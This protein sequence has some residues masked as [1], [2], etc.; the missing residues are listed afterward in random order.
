[1]AKKS[2][3]GGKKRSLPSKAPKVR[4]KRLDASEEPKQ[5]AH[6]PTVWDGE[7]E[8]RILAHISE[9]MSDRQACEAVGIA[10][11]TLWRKTA[12]DAGFCTASTR[13]RESRARVLADQ[14]I[15]IADE[16]ARMGMNGV[17]S[18]A[19]THRKTRI[20]TRFRLLAKLLPREYG[21]K[22]GVEH[23]AQGGLNIK[24]NLGDD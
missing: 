4:A 1:M 18:G 3:T 22:V 17:D 2:S 20:E 21:D 10:Q 23:S 6:R 7:L 14:I 24:I 16:P 5:P 15:E 8:K 11:S 13:A 19:E 12:E 9:G